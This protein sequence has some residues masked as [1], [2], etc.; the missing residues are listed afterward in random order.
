LL[1]AFCGIFIGLPRIKLEFE[2]VLIIGILIMIYN[3]D[4]RIFSKSLIKAFEEI[5]DA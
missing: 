3:P 4:G 5:S 2:G 1:H